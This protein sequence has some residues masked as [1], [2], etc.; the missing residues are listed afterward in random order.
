MSE[1]SEL[2]KTK[3][4]AILLSTQKKFGVESATVISIE[5][6]PR[7]SVEW[8]ELDD[9]SLNHLLGHGTPR[10]RMIEIYGPESSG[11]TSLACYICGQA[12]RV[13][14]DTTGGLVGYIDVENALDSEYAKTFGFDVEAAVISQPDSGEQALDIAESWVEQDMDIIVIDSVAALVPEAELNGEMGDASMGGQARLM[15][16][17]CRKLTA[18]LSRHRTTIIWI[19]QMRM[20]I[21][22]MF[23]NPETTSGGNALKYYASIRLDVRRRD[24]LEDP[25]RGGNYGLRARIKAVKNKVAPP[26]RSCTIDIHFGKGI[27][28]ELSWINFA[29]AYDVIKKAGAGWMTLPDGER[30]QGTGKLITLMK[31]NAETFKQITDETKVRMAANPLLVVGPSD[32]EGAE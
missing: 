17:A 8:L 32:K 5:Q 29:I 21:G 18:L 30:V 11:K 19:N 15:S 20:K 25:A 24:W 7:S 12:Q 16:K 14:K 31:E 3:L 9:P 10:G 13:L 2:Q 23:G 1:L 6:K 27:Q 28:T 4:N 22:V 26:M